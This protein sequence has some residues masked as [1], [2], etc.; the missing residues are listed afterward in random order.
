MQNF[1][2]DYSISPSFYYT[3]PI[4]YFVFLPVT[5]PTIPISPPYSETSFQTFEHSISNANYFMQASLESPY[6]E[7]TFFSPPSAENHMEKSQ[8]IQIQSND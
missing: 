8:E 4:Q 2:N 3:T 1:S 5:T 6:V 7:Q